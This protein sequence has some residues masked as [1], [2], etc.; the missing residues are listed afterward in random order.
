MNQEQQPGQNPKDNPP[1]DGIGALGDTPDIKE[2][3]RKRKTIKIKIPK[4]PA[5]PRVGTKFGS[6]IAQQTPVSV[7]PPKANDLPLRITAFIIVALLGLV[8]CHFFFEFVRLLPLRDFLPVVLW[9][10]TLH[11]MLGVAVLI[12]FGL[13]ETTRKN[14]STRSRWG[15]CIVLAAGSALFAVQW[16]VSW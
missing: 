7:E 2:S 15:Y 9:P 13:F 4:K 5:A 12:G 6:V 8:S 14:L 1:T 3:S 11:R 16:I 10:H